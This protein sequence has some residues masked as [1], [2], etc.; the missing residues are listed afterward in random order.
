MDSTATKPNSKQDKI[1]DSLPLEAF[2]AAFDGEMGLQQLTRE[3]RRVVLEE[4]LQRPTGGLFPLLDLRR[5]LGAA[6]AVVLAVGALAVFQLGPKLTQQDATAVAA[7]NSIG[8]LRVS[9]SDGR[10]VLEWSAAASA[11]HRVVRATD[12]RELATA[13][14]HEVHGNTWVDPETNGAR[15]IFYRVDEVM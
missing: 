9:S 3:R 12:P 2:Q 14:A 10:V 5:A 7:G 8:D 15:L 11:T 13:P 1:A 4:A 6:A